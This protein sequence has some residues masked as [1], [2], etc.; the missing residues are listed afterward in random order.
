VRPATALDGAAVAAVK[1]RAFGTNY[2]GGVLPDAFL[3][4]RDVVPPASYWVGRA[5][6]PPSRRHRLLVWGRPGTV[7]GYVDCGPAHPDDAGDRSDVGEVWELYVDPAAQGLGGGARLLAAA[8]A[9]LD[10]VGLVH[11]ELSVLRTNPAALAFYRRQGWQPTGAVRPVDLGVVAFEELRLRRGSPG[12]MNPAQDWADGSCRDRRAV[13]NG[14]KG[15]ATPPQQGAGLH[16]SRFPAGDSGEHW[17]DLLRMAS[18]PSPQHPAGRGSA[19]PGPRLR[20]R[21]RGR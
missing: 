2:R 9:W 18:G 21:G 16:R 4:G 17:S 13:D 11:Q 3:D 19:G 10:E 5:M 1:W 15:A 6:V 8:S 12:G 14:C 7:Y 20:R